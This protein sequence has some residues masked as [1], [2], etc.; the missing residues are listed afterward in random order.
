MVI[1][2]WGV[3]VLRVARDSRGLVHVISCYYS[4]FGRRGC[5]G[6]L[7]SLKEQAFRIR[8]NFPHPLNCWRRPQKRGGCLASLPQCGSTAVLADL[9]IAA[10]Q[11]ICCCCYCFLCLRERERG[12]NGMKQSGYLLAQHILEFIYLF[13]TLRLQLMQLEIKYKNVYFFILYRNFKCL[14]NA[15]LSV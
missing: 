3:G 9:T 1:V 2:V 12:N 7:V 15:H 4:H 11:C 8:G 5:D 14:C 13:T 6:I 10:L